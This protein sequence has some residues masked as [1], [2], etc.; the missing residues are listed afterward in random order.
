MSDRLSLPRALWCGIAGGMIAGQ[1]VGIAEA[2][3]RLSGAGA[4]EYGALVIA[5]M[6]YAVAGAVLGVGVGAALAFISLALRMRAARVW[7]LGFLAV[8]GGLAVGIGG[9]FSVAPTL[10]GGGLAAA[11]LLCLWLMPIFLTRTPLKILL[12]PRGTF[13]SAAV[14]VVLCAVFSLSP[15]SD[16]PEDP[17]PRDQSGLTERPDLLLVM[18]DALRAD[19]LGLYGDAR[20]LTPTL[21]G[22]GGD[23]V[24]FERAIA[25]ASTT[26]PATASLLT[27]MW[28]ARHGV[29]SAQ[30]TLA[31]GVA[32]LAEELNE[33]GYATGALPAHIDLTTPDLR[34][35]F[36]RVLLQAPRTLGGVGPSA[37]R[38]SLYGVV[39]RARNAALRGPGPAAEHYAPA[40]TVLESARRF[41][42]ESDGR[43]WFL[44]VHLME[45]T[46]PY[47]GA[48]GRS[49]G[50]TDAP[51]DPADRDLLV[52]RYADEVSAVDAALGELLT[53]LDD[54]GIH[55]VIAITADHGEELFDH[56]GWRHGATLY[57]EQLHVPLIIRMPD[58]RLAGTRVPWAVSQVDIPASMLGLAGAEIPDGWQ[59]R[60][61]LSPP[62]IAA[63]EALGGEGTATDPAADRPIVSETHQGG[64]SVQAIRQGGWKYIR[65]APGNP[66]GLATEE[67]YDLRADPGERDDLAGHE[68]RRQAEMSRALRA[69][70]E[71]AS[72][73]A[74]APGAM[75]C[76]ECNRLRVMGYVSDCAAVCGEEAP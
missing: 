1:L 70:L 27:G 50:P 49:S 35:G 34:R 36:D 23:A 8:G 47:Y 24:V 11:A 67:L 43:R 31:D 22:L 63:Y 30:D 14:V 19:H 7:T 6:A 52:R 29:R 25:H 9:T 18:I 17:P 75:S 39:R 5:A 44:F 53:W 51:P 54:S 38:L 64:A 20:G 60:D 48:D 13:A 59:G 66:R 12:E 72:G 26:R 57:E 69:A 62:A 73:A 28:P 40:A 10:L 71:A 55:P 37:S 58:D 61:L 41:I 74:G 42:A 4:G 15:G 3:V 56:G 2:L 45:P 16:E 33:A 46:A 68:S 65:A 76:A 21:D 32:T